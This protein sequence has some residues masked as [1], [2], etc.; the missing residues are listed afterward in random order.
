MGRREREKW[1]GAREGLGVER[2]RGRC[3]E[4]GRVVRD[5]RWGEVGGNNIWDEGKEIG[6]E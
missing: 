2:W 1:V 6:W 4:I 5:S 3:E